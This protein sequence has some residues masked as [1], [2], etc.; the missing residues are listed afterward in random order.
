MVLAINAISTTDKEL[1]PSFTSSANVIVMERLYPSTLSIKLLK[2]E[3][4][5]LHLNIP[6]IK[7]ISN[8]PLL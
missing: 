4:Y 5:K 1:N 6:V 3:R 7:C 8:N 2:R